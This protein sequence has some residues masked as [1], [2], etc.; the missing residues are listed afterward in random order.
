MPVTTTRLM[1][2]PSAWRKRPGIGQPGIRAAHADVQLV[3][4]DEVDGVLDGQDLLGRVVRDLAAEFLLERHHQLDRVEAVGAQ[5]VDKA[6][7]L[8]HLRL[9]DAEMLDDDLL[10]PLSDVAHSLG[11]SRYQRC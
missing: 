2:K 7:V 4:L 3:L 5:V 11:L 1:L 9:V 8:G 10:D 6:G